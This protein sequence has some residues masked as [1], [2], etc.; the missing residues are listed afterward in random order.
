ME[1]NFLS[2]D[3]VAQIKSFIDDKRNEDK[4][5][6]KYPNA[7]LREDIFSM[8]DGYC[9]VVY[10]P[11]ENETINGF[12]ITGIIDACGKENTFVY[13]NTAQTIEKQVFTAAHELGHIW[14]IDELI[15]SNI[16][17]M[18]SFDEK[19]KITN[20]F[21]AEL[22]MP[23]Q[24]FHTACIAEFE[25]YKES[26]GTI[27]IFNLLKSV[28][29]LMTNFFVPYKAVIHRIAELKIITEDTANMLLGNTVIPY[30]E[31][32]QLIDKYLIDIG[33]SKFLE[34]TR[35][36]WIDGLSELL[37]KAQQQ[38]TVSENKIKHLRSLFNL[39]DN[40]HISDNLD[41][42]LNISLTGDDE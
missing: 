13:I 10:F 7:L 25:R 32:T 33:Y 27:T 4:V 18:L 28:A 26:E 14:G 23:E 9:T 2:N 21:A 15:S 16:K 37:D 3:I 1:L 34:P 20:R 39:P 12:H 24:I 40:S 22:L 8:L 38:G 42:K 30:D 35:K 19:E 17:T 29:T 36:C 11:L 5:K 31:I 41:K 6:T